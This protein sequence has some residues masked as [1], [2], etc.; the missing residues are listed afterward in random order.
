MADSDVV[1][2]QKT[3]IE[4][5]RREFQQM[6]FALRRLQADAGQTS[7]Q[8]Q[9]NMFFIAKTTSEITAKAAGVVGTG[10]VDT[11]RRSTTDDTRQKIGPSL[12]VFND[13]E[14]SIAS[15]TDVGIHQDAG[16]DWWVTVE[17]CG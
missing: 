16:G 12:T 6:Q 2:W 17:D 10:T 5:L 4:Q 9:R 8:V 15:G 1:F 3:A 14:T 7:R 13:V 11:Y